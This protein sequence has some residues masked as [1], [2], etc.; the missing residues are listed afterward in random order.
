MGSIKKSALD[1][2]RES[3]DELYG[4]GFFDKYLTVCNER[5]IFNWN[6][7]KPT[8]VS[9]EHFNELRDDFADKYSDSFIA[10]SEAWDRCWGSPRR[11]S[12]FR[13]HWYIKVDKKFHKYFKL[14]DMMNPREP[15]LYIFD[16]DK[17]T[18]NEADEEVSASGFECWCKLNFMFKGIRG[19]KR[20]LN[21]QFSNLVDKRTYRDIKLCVPKQIQYG[22]RIVTGVELDECYKADISSAFPSSIVNHKLP[23]LKGCKRVKG[24]A[25]PTDEFPFAFYLKSH[26]LWIKDEFKTWDDADMMKRYYKSLVNE[27]YPTGAPTEEEETILCKRADAEDE[28]ALWDV[29]QYL[30][31]SRKE[32]SNFKQI[33]VISI[34]F[35]HRNINPTLSALAAVTIAR[36]NHRIFNICRELKAQGNIILLVATDSVAWKGKPYAGATNDKYLGSFTY[37]CYNNRIIVQGCKNYQYIDMKGNC[38]SKA[39]GIKREIS[40]KWKFGEIPEVEHT[41]I[42]MDEKNAKIIIL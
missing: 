36:T 1:D 42:M 21:S 17:N 12:M 31:D 26:H 23:Q 25:E 22:N 16:T 32:D 24:F 2:L 6:H 41:K 34:G 15:H 13:Y 40:A 5:F 18:K 39:A 28:T 38:V 37:E 19:G 7:V 8:Y 27:V 10:Q 30:Y 14:Y 11:F 33:M 9:A 3:A 35:F 20:S 4:K 29:Y